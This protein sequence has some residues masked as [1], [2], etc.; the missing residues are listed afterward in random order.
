MISMDIL[1]D[2]CEDDTTSNLEL[3]RIKAK[4][5]EIWTQLLS[6]SHEKEY[7]EMNED[8][9]DYISLEHYLEHNKLMFKGDEQPEDEID[10]L[11]DTFANLLEPQEE[12]ESISSDAKAPTYGSSSI[13]ANKDTSKVPKG[14]YKDEHASTKTP[15]DSQT[16]AKSSSYVVATGVTPTSKNHESSNATIKTL[17]SLLDIEHKKLLEMVAKRNKQYGVRL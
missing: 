12:L 6:A 2:S 8:N 3:D 9:D 16:K 5:M 15:S 10:S 17:Q 14:T 13:S 11:L 1:K 7:H 4:V